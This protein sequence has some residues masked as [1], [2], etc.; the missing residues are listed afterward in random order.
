MGKCC[1]PYCKGLGTFSFPRDE[2]RRAAWGRALGFRCS[3]SSRSKR[4]CALH[5]DD[6]DIIENRE[7][8]WTGNHLFIFV[9]FSILPVNY[10][11]FFFF[12]IKE[13]AVHEEC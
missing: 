8:Y 2:K 11:S 1:V 7:S 9:N 12:L 4:L 6:N 10:V 3:T 13:F 5:F